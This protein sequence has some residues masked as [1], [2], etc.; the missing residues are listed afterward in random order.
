MLCVRRASDILDKYVGG[1]E[2]QIAEA[3]D[4]AR[5]DGSFLLFDEA[6]SFL[7][8]RRSATRSWEMTKVNEFLQQMEV[9]PSVVACTTNLMENLDQASLRRFTFKIPFQFL[10]PEQAERLFWRTIE[11]QGGERGQPSDAVAAQLGRIANLTP[12]DFAAVSRRLKSLR[13]VPAAD[14]LL[15]ELMTELRVKETTSGRIGFTI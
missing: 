6:D 5:R 1:T 12:G 2:H 11:D 8:D 3:F 15:R 9:F 10:R 7:L 4:E 13:E 14:Q